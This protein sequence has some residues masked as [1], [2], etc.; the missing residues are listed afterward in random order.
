MEIVAAK[1]KVG[2]NEEVQE[3]KQLKM[4]ESLIKVHMKQ[5]NL[6][7]SNNRIMRALL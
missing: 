3:H 4:H 7:T 6:S 5:H 2:E 1:A